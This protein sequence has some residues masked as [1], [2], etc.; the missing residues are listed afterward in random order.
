MDYTFT[1][2]KNVIEDERLGSFVRHPMYC[3]FYFEKFPMP[4]EMGGGFMSM[5]D[6]IKKKLEFLPNKEEDNEAWVFFHERPYRLLAMLECEY[7]GELVRRVYMDAEF[8]QGL[9]WRGIFEPFSPEELMNE[10]DLE[11]YNKL[12]EEF[13]IYQGDTGDPHEISWTLNRSVAEW[14]ANR[15]NG[16]GVVRE[17]TIKKSEARAY[18]GGRSEE[19]IIHW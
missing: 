10:E 17:K 18:F 9:E 8:P 7:T 5:E 2:E 6:R 19:E 11:F 4:P 14:F 16:S 13:T 15:F 12:P 1:K 3:G